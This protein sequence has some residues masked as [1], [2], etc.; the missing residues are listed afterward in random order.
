MGWSVRG[1]EENVFLLL[2]RPSFAVSASCAKSRS[3][4]HCA[5]SSNFEG[6]DRPKNSLCALAVRDRKCAVVGIPI[7]ECIPR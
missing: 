5:R 3:P 7:Q 4:K 2:R 6:K 1:A